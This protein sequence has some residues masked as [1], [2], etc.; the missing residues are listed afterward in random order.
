MISLLRQ[1]LAKY[2]S[3]KNALRRIRSSIPGRRSVSTGFIQLSGA[4]LESEAGRLRNSWQ[5]DE[6]PGR[7]RVLVDRQLMHYRA[8][9]RVDVFDVLVEA[10]KQLPRMSGAG[11]LLEIG[12]SSGYYS[13]VF[14][15]AGLPF[16][17]TGCDY[18]PAFVAMARKTYP[19]LHFD[20]QDA[21]A[22]T[23]ADSHFDVVISGCCLLH[24]PDYEVAIAETARVAERYA[25][26][27][28][29]PVLP[30]L[31][32]MHFR[33]LAYGIETVEIHFGEAEFLALLNKFGLTLIDVFTLDEDVHQGAKTAV[34]TYVCSKVKT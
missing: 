12:C 27:H 28:R 1:W 4:D 30:H 15:I 9:Q 22:L 11:T 3:L 25:I 5:A 20:V 2:P 13:E 33:K 21:T 23:Y 16:T 7:Q 29:T 19:G 8:G 6:L 17:Y 14:G 31:S 34:R 10:I 18:S 26:F 32:T 24:I